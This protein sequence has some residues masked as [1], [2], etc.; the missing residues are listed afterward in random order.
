MREYVT[1]SGT[2]RLWIGATVIATGL[3]AVLLISS[4]TLSR[5]AQELNARATAAEIEMRQ[6]SELADA[7][8]GAHRIEAARR[9]VAETQRDAALLQLAALR[10]LPKI[11]LPTVVPDTCA[12][13]AARIDQLETEVAVLDRI[14]DPDSMI[15]KSLTLS[16]R[17]LTR[18][19]SDASAALKRAS[20]ELATQAT[21]TETAPRRF[22]GI[23]I[24]KVVLVPGYGAMLT[25]GRVQH[26]PVLAIGISL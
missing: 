15:I 14:V 19:L 9:A 25:G 4:S 26:G 20:T 13:F 8:L 5:Q 3:V 1:V 11:I 2:N 17:G 16:N 18:D 7:A 24:P 23:K 6:A 12:P 21:R 22:L 10:R